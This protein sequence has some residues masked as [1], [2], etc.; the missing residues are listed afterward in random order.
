MSEYRI[1]KTEHCGR[2][3][4]CLQKKGWFGIWYNPDNYDAYTT[5]IY[6]TLDEA[7]EATRIARLGEDG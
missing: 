2:E 6:D 5:G 4:F 3:W 1:K 7:N